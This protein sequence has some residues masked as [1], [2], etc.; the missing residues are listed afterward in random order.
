MF[1]DVQFFLIGHSLELL[2]LQL[3]D[4]GGVVVDFDKM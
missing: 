1:L 4:V 3:S 2:Q